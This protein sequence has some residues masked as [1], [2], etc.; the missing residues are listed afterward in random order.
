MYL[1]LLGVVLPESRPI[2]SLPLPWGVRDALKGDAFAFEAELT[3][4]PDKELLRIPNIGKVAL[5]KIREVVPYVPLEARQC[6]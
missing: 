6:A 1:P 2:D 4:T 5:R 3:H